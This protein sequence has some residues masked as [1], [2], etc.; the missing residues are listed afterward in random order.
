[1]ILMMPCRLPQWYISIHTLWYKLYDVL[2]YKQL[3]HNIFYTYDAKHYLSMVQNIVYSYDK[4]FSLSWMKKRQS[5][6]AIFA[7]KTLKTTLKVSLEKHA[8]QILVIRP[9]D[10]NLN[11]SFSHFSQPVKNFILQSQWQL[12]KSQCSSLNHHSGGK[13]S[14]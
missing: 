14:H 2:W 6:I 1:M 4:R 3:H 13:V 7:I 8:W 12:F 5:L 9:V 10:T 11:H